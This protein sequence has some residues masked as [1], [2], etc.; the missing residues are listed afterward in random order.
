MNS[1]NR[2]RLLLVASLFLFMLIAA[3][4]STA[5]VSSASTGFWDHYIIYNFSRFLLWLADIFGGSYGWAIVAF[6]IIIRLIILPLTWWQSKTMMKQQEVAP[7]IQALQKKYASKDVETQ[8]KLREETQKLYAEAGVNPVIGCLPVLVQMPV[9]IALYQAIYRTSA[10]KSGSF[11]WMQLGKADPYFIMAILA[12]V[13]TF[14]TSYLTMMS[15][16]TKNATTTAMLWVMPIMI[17]VMAMNI[18]SA[19]SIY[20]VVTNAFSVG[21]TMVIQNPFKIRREREAK[22]QVKRDRE[23]ALAKARKKAT[24]KR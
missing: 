10:L 9:L 20:W 6:T 12:A 14:A 16:P 15:Q 21:Q 1:K 7:E 5:P 23:K 2:K 22:E 11:L 19:V 4:C 13:F 8:Q 18:A 17:F 3:G 24:K